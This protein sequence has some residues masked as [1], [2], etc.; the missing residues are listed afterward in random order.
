MRPFKKRLLSC[1]MCGCSMVQICSWLRV[2]PCLPPTGNPQLPVAQ[3]EWR[4]LQTPPTSLGNGRQ[5]QR[6]SAASLTHLLASQR[7]QNSED[8]CKRECGH[9]ACGKSITLHW[10]Y[11]AMSMVMD[12]VNGCLRQKPMLFQPFFSKACRIARIRFLHAQ[13][14]T[15]VCH[16]SGRLSYAMRSTRGVMQPHRLISPSDSPMRDA[17][18]YSTRLSLPGKK[19]STCDDRLYDVCMR[20]QDTLRIC[21]CMFSILVA[22]VINEAER[23]RLK[24]RVQVVLRLADDLGLKVVGLDAGNLRLQ[25]DMRT[26]YGRMPLW[27]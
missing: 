12:A 14:M 23:R 3:R 10:V 26:R 20:P 19:N 7:P 5:W 24:L 15:L 8:A 4:L 9:R 6:Q 21:C 25:P 2:P 17:L 1:D 27:I 11:R 13:S 22:H 18:L 16:R